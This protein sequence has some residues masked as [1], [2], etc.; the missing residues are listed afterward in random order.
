MDDVVADGARIDDVGAG[1]YRRWARRNA[2]P[3]TVVVLGVLSLAVLLWTARI[4]ERQRLHSELWCAIA[5]FEVRIATAHL[6]LEEA[7][8]EQAAGEIGTS[9]WQATMGKALADLREARILADAL[10]HGGPDLGGTVLAPPRD[11]ALRARTERWDTCS[12]SGRRSCA[13]EYS[14]RSLA[15]QA[16]CWNNAVTKSSRTCSAKRPPSSKSCK[17][18]SAPTSPYRGG[19]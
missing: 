8:A 12:P 6:W 9:R 11:P 7:T 3:L 17:A 14:A 4:G 15:G 16:P 10:V 1:R 2:V 19:L 13:S 18:T 5:D